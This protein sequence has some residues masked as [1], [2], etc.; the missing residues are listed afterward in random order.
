MNGKFF[1]ALVCALSCLTVSAQPAAV[2]NESYVPS[3]GNLKARTEFQDAK[4]GIFL[5]WG[6]YSLLG[7]GEWAMNIRDINYLEY[8][9]LANAFYPHDFDAAEWVSAIKSSGA[10]YICFTTRHHDGFSMFET[11][12]SDYNIV[13]ASPYGKDVVKALAE[14]CAAQDVKLHLYYSLVDWYR[15]DYPRGRTG[16][17]TGRPGTDISYEHYYNFMKAQLS[18]LLTNYG[19]V[20]AIWFDGVWD[21]DV[22]PDFDWKLRGLYDHI[23]AIQPSCLVGNNHHLAPFEGEDI[24]IFERDLPGENTAGLSGQDISRLPLE[25]C[26]TMNGMW[27]YKI[28][29]LDYK[30]TAT[31]VQYLVRAAGRDGNLLLNIGP[32]PDGKL[33]A[34]AVE[35][36][37]E[38]GVWLDRYGESIYGTRGGDIPPHA[39]GVTTRKGD[40]LYVHILDLQD[41]ALY[42]Q[43][44][45][46]VVAAK[47]LNTGKAVK[48]DTL[49]GKGIVLHLHDIPHDIDR[50]VELTVR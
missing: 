43:L 22:H 33:P 15:D 14:E 11:E 9:K 35:R 32:Q 12:Q 31:L 40:R 17:G 39:W 29:D 25:T 37:R 44:T 2:S 34:T 45:S 13:D 50:I 18:E 23:H 5:H 27:G 21:Q 38:M 42:L 6:L 4:F 49:K 46:K 1:L 3:E 47:C 28:T 20:G 16:L 26:Q 41:D 8:A 19:P 10:G 48:F 36:L 7:S 24:Q 30:S